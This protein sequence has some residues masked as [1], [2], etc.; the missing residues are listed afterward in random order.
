[1]LPRFRNLEILL[2][3]LI[4]ATYHQM[5][6][7]EATSTNAKITRSHEVRLDRHEK[8]ES[9]RRISIS[10]CEDSVRGLQAKGVSFEICN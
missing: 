9:G 1:V 4:E 8:K 7:Q 10:K 3:Q 6:D 5:C 2:D